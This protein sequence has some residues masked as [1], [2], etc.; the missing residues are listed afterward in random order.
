M[1]RMAKAAP[2]GSMKGRGDFGGNW[3][4]P[5][6]NAQKTRHP[7]APTGLL[8]HAMSNQCEGDQGHQDCYREH[9][10]LPQFKRVSG[11]F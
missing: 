5:G 7:S 9:H 4:D 6:P 11:A 1:S 3:A 2:N 8:A 10:A